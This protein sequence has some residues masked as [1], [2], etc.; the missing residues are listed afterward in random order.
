MSNEDARAREAEDALLGDVLLE[1]GVPNPLAFSPEERLAT[2]QAAIEEG[3]LRIAAWLNVR[4][5]VRETGLQPRGSAL[6]CHR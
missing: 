1:L 4:S 5:G 6:P 2:I 3:R